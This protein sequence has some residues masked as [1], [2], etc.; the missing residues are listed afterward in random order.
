MPIWSAE[1][2]ELERLF[3]SFKGQLPD[4]EKELGRLIKADDENMILLYSRRCLEVI[5]TDLCEC[6]LKRPRKTEPL[7][8]IIDKLH[9]EEKVPPHIITSMHGLNE[10]STYGA[11]PKDFDPEQVK[12]VL[13]NLDIVIKW[14]LKYK[15]TQKDVKAK[16]AE[17]INQN[18]KKTEGSNKRIPIPKKRLIGL[19]S[20]L[21]LIIVVVVVAVL[22][23]TNIIGNRKQTEELEKSIAVLPFTNES[24]SDSNQYFINGLMD[25]ILI[26]LQKIKSFTKVL[27]RQSTEQYKGPDKPAI[28]EIAKRLGVSYL[29][30]GSGQKYGNVFRLRVNLIQAKDNKSIW[31]ESIEEEIKD[32]KDIFRIQTQIAQA[33]AVELK[34]VITPEEKQLIEKMHTSNLL[35]LNLY[36]KANEYQKKYEKTSDLSLYYTAVNLYREALEI[37]SAFAKAYTGLAMTYYLRYKWETYFKEN[38]LDSMRVLADR[39]LHFDDNLDEAYYLKGIYYYDAGGQIEEALENYNK[40]LKINPNLSLAYSKMGYILTY[41]KNDYINGLDCY[42]KALN[43]AP[44]KERPSVLDDLGNTYRALGLMDKAKKYFLEKLTLD[45]DSAGYFENLGYIDF[46]VGNFKNA[47]LFIEKAKKIDSTITGLDWY[48]FTGQDQEAFFD[49]EKEVEKAKK[50]GVPQLGILHRIGY[51]Y[52]KVGKEKEALLFFNEQ[53]KN[54]SESIRLHRDFGSNKRAQYDLAGI[55]AFLGYKNKA[56]KYL[57]EFNTMDFYP[58]WWVIYVKYDPLFDSIRNEEKFQKILRNV[59]AK[60]QA[61]HDRV[62]KWLEEQGML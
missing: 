27:P 57:D 35:A 43:L 1:I 30:W 39:A 15:G 25:E 42:H 23:F 12:P 28:P 24:P 60:Y 58:S 20:G 14:Y 36:L 3:E 19:V 45:V 33:I 40:A 18:I 7:K 53:I 47:I 13:V 16:Q 51:A 38:Y 41:I 32:T 10:L 21:V 29:V 22:F 8:G 52:W 11:H 56:F 34:A 49:A 5:I 4:L 48:N 54:L 59:E 17:E 46:S 50:T 31:A 26:N 55:Y 61:E 37:D 2:K 9:K 6:E 62:R 44:G